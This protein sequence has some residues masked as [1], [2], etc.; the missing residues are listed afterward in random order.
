VETLITGAS[1]YIGRYLCENLDNI[2]ALTHKECPLEDMDAVRRFKWDGETIVH[3]A[4]SGEYGKSSPDDI[5]RN[6]AMMVNMR[7]RWPEAKIIAFGSGAVYDKSK[8]ICHASEDDIAYPLDYYGLSKRA[9]IGL[10][11]TTLIPFGLYGDTRFVES[12]RRDLDNVTIYQD[13]KFSWV[14]VCDLPSAVKWAIKNESGRYNLCGYDM[15][16]TEM[17]VH[18]GARKITYLKEGMGNEYT[19]KCSIIPL[20]TC[21]KD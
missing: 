11:D 20:T 21:P 4:H 19:G 16:L 15:T 18:L 12:V 7:L 17:A 3:C 5:G 2:K 8:P 1:G 9:T 6:I 13:V 10:A 14:N